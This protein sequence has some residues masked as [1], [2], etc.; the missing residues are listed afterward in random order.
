MSPLSDWET[1]LPV[2][3]R[4]HVRALQSRGICNGS[5]LDAVLVLMK[6]KT[7]LAAIVLS[8]VHFA[9]AQ[10]NLAFPGAEGFGQFAAGGTGGETVRVTTLDDSGTNRGQTGRPGGARRPAGYNS[11]RQQITNL[12]YAQTRRREKV[13]AR[14]Q[15]FHGW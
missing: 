11:A 5:G 15:N 10:T 6:A 7:L 14:K 8:A 2:P 13:C 1:C 9:S 4:G 12:R 3:K